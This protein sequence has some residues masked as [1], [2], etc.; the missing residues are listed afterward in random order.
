M[1]AYLRDGIYIPIHRVTEEHL[2]KMTARFVRDS[3]KKEKVCEACDYF[4]E[5]PGDV[6]A[7]CPN[8]NGQIQLFDKVERNDKTYYKLPYGD[9]KALDKIFGEGN[10]TLVDKTPDIPMSRTFEFTGKLVDYQQE[11]YKVMRK[12]RCGIL[13]SAPRT[14]KTVMSAAVI[15]KMGLKTVILASQQEWLDNFYETFVGSDSQKPLTNIKKSKIGFPK[16]VEDAEKLDIALFTYQ[17]FLS[18]KGKKFLKKIRRMFSVMVVDEVQYA[19]APE[20]AAVIATFNCKHKFGLSGTPQRKDEKHWIGEKLIGKIFH[21][22]TAKRLRPSVRTVETKLGG[23]MPQSWSYIVR[24]IETDPQRLK[25]IAKE[26]IAAVKRKHQVLI[27]FARVDVIKALTSAINRLAGENIAASF[28]G[29][30]K[31]R[32]ELI[33][34]ARAYKIKIIV[35]N[36]RLLSTGVNIPRASSLFEVTPSSNPPKAEQRFSRVLT[37][38]EGKPMPEIVYFLDNVDVRR[39][40]I[41]SEFFQVL[42]KDFKPIFS[43]EERARFYKYIG[44]KKLAQRNVNDYVGGSI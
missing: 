38:F 16:N 36:I 40:C 18:P 13:K 4:D 11:A 21:T 42:A 25:L 12:T 27:P 34:R 43:D 33:D 22:T 10:V 23:K 44:Q 6:C 15:A 19:S 2:E 29:A 28:Y 41:R 30:T 39:S 24:K 37:P 3:Y 32:K 5:R 8:Y 20:F 26:A 7:N 31:G 14:G 9:L 35:G 17:T 1:K